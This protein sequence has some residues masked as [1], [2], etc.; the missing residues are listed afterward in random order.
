MSHLL[1]GVQNVA[2]CSADGVAHW[3]LHSA[4]QSLRMP[5][6]KGFLMRLKYVAELLGNWESLHHCY[7]PWL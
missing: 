5:D 3:R 6:K 2:C 4:H 7:Y 1:G